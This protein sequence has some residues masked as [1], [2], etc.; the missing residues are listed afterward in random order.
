MLVSISDLEQL[1]RTGFA[2]S[3]WLMAVED[4]GLKQVGKRLYIVLSVASKRKSL[5]GKHLL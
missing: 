2:S 1:D 5:E 4:G 3:V